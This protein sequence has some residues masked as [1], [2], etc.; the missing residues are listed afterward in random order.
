MVF[1][2]SKIKITSLIILIFTSAYRVDA[3]KAQDQTWERYAIDSTF[4]GADG[5]RIADVNGD[6]IPDVTT[7]WEEEGITKVYLHPGYELVKEIWPSVIVGN[8]PSVEDALFAD[9]NNDGAVDIVTSTEGDH[10]KIYINWAPTEPDHYLDASKWKTEVLSISDGRMQWMFA[11][12]AQIDGG[13]GINLVAGAKNKGAEI[14]WFQASENPNDLSRWSWHPISSAQWVMSLIAEDMDQDG[15]FDILTS[16]RKKGETNGIRWLENP[17]ECINQNHQWKNH[18]IG[19]RGLEV[20]FMD[21]ADLDRD[22]LKDVIVT[23]RSTQKIF[24]FRK[25]D[26]SGLKWKSYC[27]DIPQETGKAKAVKVGDINGDGKLDLVH[28]TNTYE[29]ENKAGIYWLSYL[30]KPTDSQWIWHELSGLEG[31]KFDRIELLDIDGDGDLDV[32]TTEENYGT[33]SKGLG[34]IWYENPIN[35]NSNKK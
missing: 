24:F 21:F 20:M 9:I 19:A 7:G 25:L 13:N 35:K 27:I 34:V 22:G 16:D 4:S 15:D 14:G 8:T 28:T 11:T 6:R 30:N 1:D 32:L 18:F 33:N 10:K 23:E 3:V 26:Q 2:I 29:D 17:G 31:Y 5:V 12:T